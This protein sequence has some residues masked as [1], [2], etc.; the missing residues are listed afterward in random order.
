MNIM[1]A[2]AIITGPA[3]LLVRRGWWGLCCAAGW[4][5]AA[6]AGQTIDDKAAFAQGRTQ[7][8]STLAT[9]AKGAFDRVEWVAVGAGLALAWR[10]GREH[11]HVAARGVV[12][13]CHRFW[14]WVSLRHWE[15]PE[16]FELPKETQQRF[17]MLDEYVPQIG[18]HPEAGVLTA[19]VLNDLEQECAVAGARLEDRST[20]S[21]HAELLHHTHIVEKLR[22]HYR[23]RP[24]DAIAN[25]TAT[26]LLSQTPGYQQSFLGPVGALASG[27][28]WKL[29]AVSAGAAALFFGLWHHD[30][31]AL[32]RVKAERDAAAANLTAVAGNRQGWADYAKAEH[33][34]VLAAG[35]QTRVTAQTIE[36]ER[37][38]VRL[39]AARERA[40]Q[41]EL[42]KV[43]TGIGGPPAWDGLHTQGEPAASA[44]NGAEAGGDVR[45]PARV[46]TNPG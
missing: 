1:E 10:N 37:K 32:G 24:A 38:T 2:L 40:R 29:A 31:G 43:L 26:G 14:A 11:L 21:T 15:K 20:K 39:A 28:S 45:D 25:Q 44:G 33:A 36:T 19:G 30:E 3:F 34:K 16:P 35:E 41:N 8:I 46:P 12:R 42:R 23:L 7:V 6:Q 27:L 18:E 4:Y 9:A 22:T 5:Q 13:D 17:D